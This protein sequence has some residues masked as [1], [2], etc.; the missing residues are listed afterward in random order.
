MAVFVIVDST[1]TLTGSISRDEAH[2]FV[3]HSHKLL[4]CE[5]DVVTVDLT[6]VHVADSSFLGMIA[7]LAVE[8]GTRSKSLVIRATGKVADLVAWAGLHRIAKL[9]LS[10]GAGV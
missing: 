6:G 2:A 3:A 9:E 8:A 7:E 4:D 1:L 10:A 5:S